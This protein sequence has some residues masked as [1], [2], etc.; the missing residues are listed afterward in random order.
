M[1][2]SFPILGISCKYLFLSI[3]SISNSANFT[4]L[5]IIKNS[6]TAHFVGSSLY[7]V[8]LI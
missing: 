3:I 7:V 6:F 4:K 8:A 2:L 5:L 1:F